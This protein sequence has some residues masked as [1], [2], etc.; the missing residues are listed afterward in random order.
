MAPGRYVAEDGLVRLNESP[1]SCVGSMPRFR[2][3]PG[4]GSRSGSV[5]KQGAEGNG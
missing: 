3:M 2:G 1:W 5:G 4:Q